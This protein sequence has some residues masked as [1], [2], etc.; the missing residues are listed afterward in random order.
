MCDIQQEA[1]H[2]KIVSGS[3][4]KKW[5]NKHNLILHILLINFVDFLKK[6]PDRR[7]RRNI[8]AKFLGKKN[9]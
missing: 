5:N 4:R 6:S 7:N 2:D 9:P 1:N 8:L 3:Y